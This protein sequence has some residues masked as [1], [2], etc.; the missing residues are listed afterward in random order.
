MN[1]IENNLAIAQF[2]GMYKENELLVL[3]LGNDEYY[4]D[5]TDSET[6]KFKESWDWVMPIVEKIETLDKYR[7][8]VEMRQSIITIYDKDNQEDIIGIYDTD[9]KID[10]VYNACISFIHWYNQQSK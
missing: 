2:M 7:F 4:I 5:L 8:D 9:R 1:N 3:P 10:A 6:F